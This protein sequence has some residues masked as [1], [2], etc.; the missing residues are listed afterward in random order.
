MFDQ[1]T[2]FVNWHRR[3]NP[4]ARTWRDYTYDLKQF[5]DVVGERE[6]HTITVTDID[7]FVG[8]Q[9]GRGLSP[10]TINRRLT[11]LVSFY[12]Y[13]SDTNVNNGY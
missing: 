2:E 10:K 5:V 3:R 4:T 8:R 1:I 11:T 12:T 13:L 9:S 6:P 7:R